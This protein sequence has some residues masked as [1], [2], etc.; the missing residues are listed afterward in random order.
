VLIRVAPDV[1]LDDY[2]LRYNKC[3]Q[4]MV[5]NKKR[6]I[7]MIELNESSDGSLQRQ[8]RHMTHTEVVTG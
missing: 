8:T 2:L 3:F 7:G 4:S 5:A 1:F 6:K